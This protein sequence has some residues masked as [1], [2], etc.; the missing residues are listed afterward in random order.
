[1]EDSFKKF[2]IGY[3]SAGHT[4]DDSVMEELNA[5]TNEFINWLD[6][7]YLFTENAI[8]AYIE[9]LKERLSDENRHWFPL[10]FDKHRYIDCL[11]N[12]IKYLLKN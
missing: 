12:W 6:P 3:V 1:M 5:L 8:G 2:L 4:V 10:R 7:N 9:F 11:V